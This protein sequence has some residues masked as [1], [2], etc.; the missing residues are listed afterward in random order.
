VVEKV[1]QVVPQSEEAVVQRHVESPIAL[2]RSEIESRMQTSASNG[3]SR[4]PNRPEA[5]ATRQVVARITSGEEFTFALEQVFENIPS[6]L[7]DHTP[8]SNAQLFNNIL[9]AV[10]VIPAWTPEEVYS[11]LP[12]GYINLVQDLA[13]PYKELDQQP[14][15]VHWVFTSDGNLTSVYLTVIPSPDTDKDAPALIAREL[16]S[17][18]E[19]ED[20]GL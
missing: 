5:N 2:N 19:R 10:T 1:A 16:L 12:N 15:L 6:C 8:R 4:L 11:L 14:H 9:V 18:Q 3:S 7:T 13:G 20:L 17:V